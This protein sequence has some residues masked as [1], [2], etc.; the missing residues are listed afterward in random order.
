MGEC[1]TS[2]KPAGRSGANTAWGLVTGSGRVMESLG[3]WGRNAEPPARPP[4]STGTSA[5]WSVSGSSAA[6]GGRGWGFGHVAVLIRRRSS[7][8]LRCRELTKGSVVVAVRTPRRKSSGVRGKGWISGLMISILQTICHFQ[9]IMKYQCF[10]NVLSL[11][12]SKV[13]R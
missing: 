2:N 12:R 1:S 9:K 8:L 4:G 13:E 3:W 11:R 5:P 10:G 6:F 7:T